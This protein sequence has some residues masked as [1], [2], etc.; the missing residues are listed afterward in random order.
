[1]TI[2]KYFPGSN[3]VKETYDQDVLDAFGKPVPHGA[4]ISY[5]KNGNKAQEGAHL[6]GRREG[7]WTFWFPSGIKEM[8]V[9]YSSGAT[10]GSVVQYRQTGVVAVSGTVT[11]GVPGGLWL[12]W[13]PDGSPKT[14]GS[15][16]NGK[17]SGEWRFWD[18]DGNESIVEY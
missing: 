15:Y 2:T 6:A 16:D 17:R 5:W 14:T 11:A 9:T 13:Y 10:Y 4:Y 12:S 7:P 18:A 1:M 8:E 3:T